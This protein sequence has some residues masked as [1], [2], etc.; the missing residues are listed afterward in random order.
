MAMITRT[1]RQ[2]A[3][4]M[5]ILLLASLQVQAGLIEII[6]AG[7][8]GNVTLSIEGNALRLTDNTGGSGLLRVFDNPGS[9][10]NPIAQ[11]GFA[12][13]WDT[14]TILSV[15]LQEDPLLPTTRLDSL[16]GGVGLD[17]SGNALKELVIFDRTGSAHTIDLD[18]SEFIGGTVPEPT[19]V[20]LC[21]LLAPALLA[22]RFNVA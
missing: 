3:A 20:V 14:S 21:A 15:P 12:G 4:A 19:S 7:T 22:R 18:P 16:F 1:I 6:G 11:L 5:A 17:I 13:I 2:V 10:V 8:G 9:G